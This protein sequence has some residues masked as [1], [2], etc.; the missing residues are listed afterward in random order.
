MSMSGHQDR[1]EHLFVIWSCKAYA[2][3]ERALVTAANSLSEESEVAILLMRLPPDSV[4]ELIMQDLAP[5][6]R[7]IVA[8][9][10][11]EAR[12]RVRNA[13][14]PVLVGIW[15]VARSRVLGPRRQKWVWWEHS[16]TTERLC[17][18]ARLR[19]LCRLAVLSTGPS[20]V[21]VPAAFMKSELERRVGRPVTVI[22]NG[23]VEVS[24]EDAAPSRRSGENPVLGTIGRLDASRRTDLAIRS[25]V[26][27][28]WAELHVAGDGP[29][30]SSLQKLALEL[31]LEHRVSFKGWITDKAGFFSAIDLLVVTSP[32]ETFGYALF[33]AAENSV[34]VVACPNPR[35]QEVIP[36]LVPG[37]LADGSDELEIA[38][39]VAE[40]L[41]HPAG[42]GVFE[43]AASLRKVELSADLVCR[44]WRR[45][46]RSSSS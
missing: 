25:L 45:V 35:T 33:E 10:L 12:R 26:H 2:G 19:L 29:D 9:S 14:R 24:D 22:P 40:A 31:G 28:P 44:K 15:T 7:L 46:L 27:L 17:L 16:I 39:A 20:L 18:S 42:V 11:W 30:R 1:S 43:S 37:L 41:E 38:V 3:M 5:N 32:T 8:P 34:Q 36:R 23:G 6:V 13:D 4:K 21:V